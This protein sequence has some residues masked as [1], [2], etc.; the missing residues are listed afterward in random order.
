M[1]VELKGKVKFKPWS[2]F[3]HNFVTGEV[4]F[5][6]DFD[7]KE[8]AQDR[9]QRISKGLVMGVVFKFVSLAEHSFSE[10]M[11]SQADEAEWRQRQ[12][13]GGGQLVLPPGGVRV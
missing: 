1:H 10:T 5:I 12:S 4:K 3:L 13:K 7:T 11:D 6:Q 8:D 2:V 9:S